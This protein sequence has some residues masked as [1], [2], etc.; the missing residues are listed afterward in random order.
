MMSLTV[1]C[2][3][4]GSPVELAHR[5]VK[6]VQCSA[7]D[8]V[9]AIDKDGVDPL[10]KTATLTDFFS[11]LTIGAIA[12]VQG[13]RFQAL[14]RLRFEY[15]DG[16][17]DEWYLYFDDGS[18]AWLVED[19]GELT[20]VNPVPVPGQ[21]PHPSTLRAGE[22]FELPG[23]TVYVTEVGQ[24]KIVGMEGQIPRGHFIGLT[25]DYLD[26]TSNG[27]SFMLEFTNSEVECFVGHD[28]AFDDI[29]LEN[30]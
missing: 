24:A 2:P 20:L 15:A 19:E 21:P 1:Q 4:C 29:Q 28:I 5:N 9:S 16:Y 7:C 8:T 17:W 6:I 30:Q 22:T 3:S 18:D 14:G 13:R 27:Q 10:G 12:T 23:H 26:A 25:M 11:A